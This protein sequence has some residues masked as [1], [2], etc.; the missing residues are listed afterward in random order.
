MRNMQIRRPCMQKAL[1]LIASPPAAEYAPIFSR[2]QQPYF[3]V[4]A[5]GILGKSGLRVMPLLVEDCLTGLKGSSTVAGTGYTDLQL[6]CGRVALQPFG[7]DWFLLAGIKASV[8]LRHEGSRGCMI[9]ADTSRVVLPGLV[10]LQ[11]RHKPVL[12]VADCQALTPRNQEIG[13]HSLVCGTCS[14]EC[15]K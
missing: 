13:V 3:P 12:M 4:L 10:S 15:R 11:H 2:F 5:Q 14:S 7:P 1:L 8:C 9:E 6:L